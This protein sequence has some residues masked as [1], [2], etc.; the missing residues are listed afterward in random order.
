MPGSEKNAG[1]GPEDNKAC[2]PDGTEDCD[3]DACAKFYKPWYAKRFENIHDIIKYWQLNYNDLKEKTELFTQ[4]FYDTDLP[5]EVVEAV[6]ANLTILKSP[7]VLR[8]YDGK[9]WAWEGCSDN[10]G[11]CAGS[12]T[13]VWNYAQTISRLFPSLERSLRETEFTMSQDSLGHQTFRS[14]L[15]IRPVFHNFYAA[16]D[17]QLGGIMKIYRE[18]RIS[19]DNNWLKKI[20]P[21]VKQSFDYC[22]HE[23]DP[24]G[25]GI[26]EEPHHN[27][28]DIEFWGPDGMCTSFYLGAAKALIEMGRFL[29]DDVSGYEILLENGKAYMENN[30]W[31][32]VYFIQEIKWKGLKA[33]DPTEVQKGIML[34]Y[35]EEAKAILAKEGPKYQ[36]GSGCLSDGI[37]GCW[38]A[39]MCGLEDFI[40]E[41][42]MR[43]HLVSVHKYNLKNDLSDHANPQR[44]TYGLG[45]DGGLLLCTWPKG[46]EL[47]LPFVYSNE[48]WTGIEYQVAAHLMEMGEVE[49]GLDIVREVRKR[50]DGRIRNPFNEYECGHWYARAMSSYGMI[51]GLTGIFY[52]AVDQILYVDSQIGEDFKSFLSTETGWGTSGLKNGKPYVDVK[53]GAIPVKKY[54]LSNT[55]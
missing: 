10:S 22:S 51:Q 24:E 1:F 20:Y 54:I 33:P 18:W 19:G 49:K 55:E 25:K 15:P 14:A 36:Y 5:N 41:E 8:Q 16:A 34:N 37:L 53:Y 32:G 9:M 6:A 13:H 45:K 4:T 3:P 28:Y 43:S 29:G 47:T 12:C 52:D 2:C 11:C 48:V 50:Y 38:I 46:S 17:G 35:N 21:D 7:T 40:D 42:K 30:L 23:W 39:S 27:T 44:P 26:L 31:N